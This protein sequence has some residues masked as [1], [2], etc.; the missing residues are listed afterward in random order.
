MTDVTRTPLNITL[1]A[2][3]LSCS[4]SMCSHNTSAE[5]QTTDDYCEQYM[6]MGPRYSSYVFTN[7]SEYIDVL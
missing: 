4:Y 2:H 1:H 7:T 5:M 3:C 6:Q